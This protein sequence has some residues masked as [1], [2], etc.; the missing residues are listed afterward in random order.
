[1]LPRMILDGNTTVRWIEEYAVAPLAL[2]LPEAGSK[3]ESIR[4]PIC[5]EALELKLVSVARM[6]L[7]YSLAFGFV[8]LIVLGLGLLLFAFAGAQDSTLRLVGMIVL[9]LAAVLFVATLAFLLIKPDYLAKLPDAVQI[10][11]DDAR[12]SGAEEG[13]SGRK[14]HKLFKSSRAAR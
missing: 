11:R 3:C 1:M 8:T 13:F 5:E 4:C 14:G 9:G 2:E 12:L 10:T 7:L 6:H